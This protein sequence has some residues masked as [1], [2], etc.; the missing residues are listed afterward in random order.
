MLVIKAVIE[1]VD[2]GHMPVNGAGRS[3][4]TNGTTTG[5]SNVETVHELRGVVVP[6]MLAALI[7]ATPSVTVV[8][9]MVDRTVTS[10]LQNV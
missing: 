4:E 7:R 10:E 3:I 5:S 1:N 6:V 8:P 2:V 9:E